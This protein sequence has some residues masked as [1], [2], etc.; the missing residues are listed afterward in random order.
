MLIEVFVKD[1]AYCKAIRDL[2]IT[3]FAKM[4]IKMSNNWFIW[5]QHHIIS[6]WEE[7]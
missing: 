3:S 5:I 7:I 4:E 1:A 6:Y 2:C